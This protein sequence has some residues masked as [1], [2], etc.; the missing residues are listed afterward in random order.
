MRLFW[1]GLIWVVNVA[2]G[3]LHAHNPNNGH[4]NNLNALTENMLRQR[5]SRMDEWMNEN[6]WMDERKW[7]NGWTVEAMNGWTDE[8]L[9]RWTDERMNGWGGRLDERMNGRNFTR[10]AQV[11][12]RMFSSDPYLYKIGIFK[13]PKSNLHY[14]EA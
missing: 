5:F 13:F 4:F 8:R 14:L 12:V 3:L 11:P 7:M 9:R 10:L 2:K 6:G 1:N